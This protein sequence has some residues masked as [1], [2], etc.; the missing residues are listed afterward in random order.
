MLP[1]FLPP[2]S[3]SPLS[4][5]KQVLQTAE[6]LS[7]MGQIRPLLLNSPTV[8]DRRGCHHLERGIPAGSREVR[9]SC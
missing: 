9:A 8:D 7:M 6:P 5:P 4:P 2:P 3:P 1:L